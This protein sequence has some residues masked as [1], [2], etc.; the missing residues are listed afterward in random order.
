MKIKQLANKYKSYEAKELAR[1]AAKRKEVVPY[2]ALAN[3]KIPV[4]KAKRKLSAVAYTRAIGNPYN[5]KFP[6][7][8]KRIRRLK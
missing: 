4:V 7:A 3:K 2:K 8:T 1:R 5:V 6:K